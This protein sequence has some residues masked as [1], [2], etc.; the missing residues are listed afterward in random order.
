MVSRNWEYLKLFLQLRGQSVFK[1]P[2]KNLKIQNYSIDLAQYSLSLQK[3]SVIFSPDFTH[4]FYNVSY[5]GRKPQIN[6][7]RSELH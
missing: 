2:Q 5:A 7:L 3:M 1:I 4:E 6:T